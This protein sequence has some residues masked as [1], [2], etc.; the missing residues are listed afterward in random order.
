MVIDVSD[1]LCIRSVT[2]LLCGRDRPVGYTAKVL[3]PAMCVSE[4]LFY[5]ILTLITYVQDFRLM[6][7]ANLSPVFVFHANTIFNCSFLRALRQAI[8]LPFRS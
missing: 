4:T 5:C 2:T 1:Y 6:D 8:V 7:N 3:C